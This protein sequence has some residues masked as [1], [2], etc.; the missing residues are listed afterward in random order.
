MNEL[1]ITL[2]L[3]AW[4]TGAEVET[5]HEFA[6][7][8]RTRAIRVDCETEDIV[9]EVGLDGKASSRD[10]LH[11]ALVASA[12][13][14]KVPMVVLIDRDGVEGRY[15]QETRMVAER[16]GVHYA[17]CS[18]DFILRWRMTQPF[19]TGPGSPVGDLPQGTQVWGTC[20]IAEV[21]KAAV[22]FGAPG[23]Q[24]GEVFPM[25]AAEGAPQLPIRRVS[26]GRP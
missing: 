5:R 9:M 2:L 20:N 1:D 16:A 11:Q 12:L 21:V 8:G 24:A 23:C 6:N 26:A 17:R 13:T 18:K 4:L 7:L 25:I 19:R 22:V 15:E 10:S 3:C 14:G